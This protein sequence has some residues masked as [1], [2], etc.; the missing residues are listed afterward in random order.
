M[1]EVVAIEASMGDVTS[2]STYSGLAPIS[3]VII[4]AY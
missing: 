1:L 2:D 4:K 3:V